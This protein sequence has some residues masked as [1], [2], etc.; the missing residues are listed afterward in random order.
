MDATR[1]GPDTDRTGERPLPRERPCARPHT[2]SP[3]RARTQTHA[4]IYKHTIHRHT[5]TCPKQLHGRHN[6]KVKNRTRRGVISPARSK[7]TVRQLI[8]Q[9]SRFNLFHQPPAAIAICVIPIFDSYALE[10]LC[11]ESRSRFSQG[12][13][14]LFSALSPQ[15][16]HTP[17]SSSLIS[18]VASILAFVDRL[19]FLQHKNS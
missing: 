11:L 8:N 19:P 16:P 6:R 5:R 13:L 10:R 9:V 14:S 3:T 15:L 12:F 17:L 1:F 2:H 7:L 18:H 4:R